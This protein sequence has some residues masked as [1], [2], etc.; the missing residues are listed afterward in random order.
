MQARDRKR[1]RYVR[2]LT[3]ITIMGKATEE[4]LGDTAR[5]VLRPHFHEA[6]SP[7]KKVSWYLNQAVK[8]EST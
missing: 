2:R 6:N 5:I 3:P 7:I 8:L 1:S 4:G